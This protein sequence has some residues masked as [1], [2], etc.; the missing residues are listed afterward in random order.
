MYIELKVKVSCIPYCLDV[1]QA[2][3]DDLLPA[4]AEHYSGTNHLRRGDAMK[5][6][7][8]LLLVEHFGFLASMLCAHFVDHKLIETFFEGGCH[9]V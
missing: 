8:M 5:I 2:C 7:K 1:C 6:I 9:S 4:L 3:R